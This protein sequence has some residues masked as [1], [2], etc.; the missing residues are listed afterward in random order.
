[1]GR[2]SSA[3]SPT[4]SGTRLDVYPKVR[5]NYASSDT[6]LAVSEPSSPA[7]LRN[8]P[9]PYGD[10]AAL[11]SPPQYANENDDEESASREK[12]VVNQ[13]P[14]K[15]LII[16]LFTSIFIAFIVCLIVAAVVGRIHDESVRKHK[17]A[18]D[19]AARKYVGR[20]N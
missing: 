18:E 12:R 19:E 3:S 16:R 20:L 6:T 8:N 4:G 11:S 10:E 15:T 2:R 9:P 17:E 1:M 7:S 5:S 14:K 13:L